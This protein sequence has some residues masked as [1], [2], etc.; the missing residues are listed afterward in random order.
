MLGM[1]MSLAAFVFGYISL[2]MFVSAFKEPDKD[3]RIRLFRSG[4]G[5]LA[6]TIMGAV[7]AWHFFSS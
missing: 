1:I 3:E 4:Y 6:L 7:Y 5:T 2:S